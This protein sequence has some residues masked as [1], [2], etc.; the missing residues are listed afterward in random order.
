MGASFRLSDLVPDPMTFTDDAYGGDGQT[1]DVLTTDLLSEDAVSALMREQ[2]RMTQAFAADRGS[3]ALES[4]NRLIGILIPDLP[5]E[6]LGSIPIAFKAQFI[7]FWHAEQRPPKVVAA[8][9]TPTPNPT[10]TP[11]GRRSPA[12]SP[13]TD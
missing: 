2:R 5:A 4:V 13:P 6:R 11:R 8:T 9:K 1:Y 3:E 7:E 12:S 10:P